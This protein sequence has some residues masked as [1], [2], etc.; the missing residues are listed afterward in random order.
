MV[1]SPQTPHKGSYSH[2]LRVPDSNHTHPPTN[3]L[4]IVT[5]LSPDLENSFPAGNGHHARQEDCFLNVFMHRRTAVAHPEPTKVFLKLSPEMAMLSVLFRCTH[6]P[7]PVLPFL[8]KQN[9]SPK[10]IAGSDITR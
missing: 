2:P 5:A 9:L 4:G 7:L 10:D 1:F 6:S 3:Q 8:L